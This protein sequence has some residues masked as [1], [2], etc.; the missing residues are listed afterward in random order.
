MGAISIWERWD[1]MLE[2]GTVNPGEMTSFNH[3]ALGSV[4]AWLHAV[5]GGL[6]PLEPGWKRFKVHPRP[7]DD[8]R[9]AKIEYLSACGQIHCSW[10]LSPQGGVERFWLSLEVPG[11]STAEVVLTDGTQIV[12]GSGVYSF[13]SD[14]VP[15]GEWP[16]KPLRTAFRD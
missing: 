7:G 11:N 3:Y 5:V 14:Y 6:S 4:A 9:S 15:E 12:V 2:D 1:S 13:E 10:E 16:P 8:V